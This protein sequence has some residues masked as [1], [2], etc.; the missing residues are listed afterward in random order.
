[1]IGR[2]RRG[3]AFVLAAL[4]SMG[5]IGCGANEAPG[6]VPGTTWPVSTPA[7]EGID[8]AAVESLVADIEAGSC[9]GFRITMGKTHSC[10]QETD[11]EGS[12]C[13]SHPNMTWWWYSIRGISMGGPVTR[14]G[15]H[16]RSGSF[17]PH[18]RG[19]TPTYAGVSTRPKG[20]GVNNQG[21]SY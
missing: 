4:T 21:T 5:L 7:E 3:F 11:T 17:R 13:R 1:M 20:I 14:V 18:K 15:A 19:E 2:R 6:Q 8:P 10:L 16:C 12:S 9:G